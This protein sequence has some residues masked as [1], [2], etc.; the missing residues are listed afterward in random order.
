MTSSTQSFT[1]GIPFVVSTK[2]EAPTAQLVLRN[3]VGQVVQQWLVRQNKC[4][5]G[6]SSGCALRCELEGIAPYHALL[7]VGAKQMFLRALAPRVTRDGEPINEILLTDEQPHFEL[8][9]HRFELNRGIQSSD[10]AASEDQQ[11]MKFVLARPMEL[12]ARKSRPSRPVAPELIQEQGPAGN[13]STTAIVNLIRAAIEPL[14]CQ[15][16]NVLQPIAV[17]QEESSRQREL[18]QQ[19]SEQQQSQQIQADHEEFDQLIARRE[20][21][22]S[23]RREAA[24]QFRNHLEEITLRQSTTMDII[25]ERIADVTQ[26]L[27]TIERIV[28]QDTERPESTHELEEA[29]RQSA[30]LLNQQGGAIEQLQQGMV[31]LSSALQ[32]L[33]QDQRQEQETDEKWKAEFQQQISSLREMF[34]QW[35]VSTN[36]KIEALAAQSAANMQQLTEQTEN[37]LQEASANATP[38]AIATHL[39]AQIQQQN[40]LWQESIQAQFA[41][42][43]D[44][45]DQAVQP[46]VV[47]KTAE[48]V[49]EVVPEESTGDFSAESEW[50]QAQS[51]ASESDSVSIPQSVDYEELENPFASDASVTEETP[52]ASCGEAEAQDFQAQTQETSKD[53]TY[54]EVETF[55]EAETAEEPERPSESETIAEVEAAENE[56]VADQSETPLV[57]LE[58]VVGVYELPTVD[59][60]PYA[61]NTVVTA[62]DSA[63]VEENVGNEDENQQESVEENEFSTIAEPDYVHDS[64]AWQAD[65]LSE[66]SEDASEANLE[67]P[68]AESSWETTDD[69]QS[70]WHAGE[71]SSVQGTEDSVDE[72]VAFGYRETEAYRPEYSG[73]SEPQPPAATHEFD[74]A[75]DELAET[76]PETSA[77]APLMEESSTE[78]GSE[79]EFEFGTGP[80]AASTESALPDSDSELESEFDYAPQ[81]GNDLAESTEFE[82]AESGSDEEFDSY[83]AASTFENTN[84]EPASEQYEPPPSYESEVPG[85]VE[86]ASEF[87]QADDARESALPIWWSEEDAS[88]QVGDDSNSAPDFDSVAEATSQDA[89]LE[90]YAEPAAEWSQSVEPSESELEPVQDDAQLPEPGQFATL[91]ESRSAFDAGD[92]IVPS[93]EPALE[94]A[95]VDEPAEVQSLPEPIAEVPA[96]GVD[97]DE[98]EDVE[99]YMRKLLARMRGVPEEEVPAEA[100]EDDPVAP[101]PLTVSNLA[102]HPT[103]STPSGQHTESG[104]GSEDVEDFRPRVSAPEQ[105]K[106]L[107]AMRELAN[108]SARTAIHKSTRKRQLSSMLLKGTIAVIGLI[109]GIVLLVIN[110]FTLNI[111]LIA[112]FAAFFVAAIWGY[113][114]CSALGPILQA[115]LISQEQAEQKAEQQ[116]S[117]EPIQPATMASIAPPVTDSE[118]I[119]DS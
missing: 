42:F 99:D 21:E 59:Y 4:T 48:Q 23:A 83:P 94:E 22:E 41:Q 51:Y 40:E 113:D 103:E 1:S 46:Q 30:E 44:F 107:A 14:E 91:E 16:Q 80:A 8:A 85:A 87:T 98:N 115:G 116:A 60:V 47:I 102:G 34:E 37:R 62:D 15:L 74:A 33:S 38:D 70:S 65:S 5:L 20:A 3:D 100:D 71:D 93:S 77:E 25:G 43:R 52:E 96:S 78:F 56:P 29:S 58:N 79:N 81:L 54:A 2:T 114:A 106:S 89:G 92:A 61:S 32:N 108:T 45:M 97:Q 50:E 101:E 73:F 55:S 27:G 36:E 31:D 35:G 90:S 86:A 67:Q 7:V 118:D 64:Q 95:I 9:G 18:T 88:T 63:A 112:T 28:L 19:L 105:T 69:V 66:T 10:S 111:G 75:K 72:N 68:S 24:E 26:Q 110:G 13:N 84:V 39:T 17:L 109:V 104:L 119:I 57:N 12:H 49:S 82:S 76:E 117:V 11:R 6:S 53:E